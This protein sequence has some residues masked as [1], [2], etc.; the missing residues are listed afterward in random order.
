MNS[1]NQ[2][3]FFLNND[4]C[5]LISL[6]FLLF[7]NTHS[8]YSHFSHNNIINFHRTQSHANTPEP[9]TNEYF[10]FDFINSR[11]DFLLFY[12]ITLHQTHSLSPIWA[13]IILHSPSNPFQRANGSLQTQL[14][15]FHWAKE[16]ADGAMISIIHSP[17]SAATPKCQTYC[18]LR[19]R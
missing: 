13:N 17:H 12:T 10:L 9:V 5:H 7:N 4:L 11:H 14:Y 8:P 16:H 18:R 2:E 6:F 1:L 19:V 3:F 15:N